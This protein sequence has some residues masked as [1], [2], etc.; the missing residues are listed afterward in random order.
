MSSSQFQVVSEFVKEMIIGN[1]FITNL[2]VPEFGWSRCERRQD[3]A[4]EASA[5]DEPYPLQLLAAQQIFV[6]MFCDRTIWVHLA[7][8][9]QAGKT[10]VINSLY[11]LILS[12]SR[13]IGLAPNRIFTI[14]GMSDD[15]WRE[16]TS[17]RLPKLLREN[18]HHSG[19]LA[20]VS[21]KLESL[22]DE[23]DD[24]QLRNVLIVLDESHHAAS[25]SNRPNTHVYQVVANRCPRHLW[26]ERGIRF[27]TVSATD[28][29]KVL[30]ME[31]SNDVT[32]AVVHLETTEAYQSVESLNNSKRLIPVKHVLN[33]AEGAKILCDQVRSL[34][35]EHGPLIHILRPNA[36]KGKDNNAE[37][38]ALLKKEI[39]G[40]IVIPWDMESKK[41]NSKDSSDTA[42]SISSDI[43]TSYLSEK[44][45]RTT[46]ILL[47]G[48]F[49]AAKTLNDEH[50][51]VL[52]D[53]VGGADST[54]LQS[55]LGRACGYGKSSRS[56]IF[57][58]KS[59][60]DNYIT[61]WKD[62][63]KTKNFPKIT[64]IPVGSLKG[65][66]PG[67]AVENNQTNSNLIL[68]Q[69]ASSPLSLGVGAHVES[70]AAQPPRILPNDDD[71]DAVW[72][73]ELLT[74][75]EA[76]I[77]TGGKKMTP[78]ESTG[79]Y[80]HVGGK[81][82]P[83]TREQFIALRAGKKTAHVGK[84]LDSLKIGESMNKT[85]AFY[86]NPLDSSTVRFVVRTLTR[87]RA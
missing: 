8:E 58:A 75:E 28:P 27:L 65:K 72:S 83:M 66:M 26:S 29:A 80:A 33:T 21:A 4:D 55:L 24:K 34:E 50:V 6:A 30:A 85:I 16:Q 62:L 10:G 25:L 23:E 67:V 68:K 82:T 20:R 45:T 87:I 57:V 48:M 53:R 74:A 63:C 43:N 76:K 2:W 71:F 9:M 3:D 60:V 79:F 52:Y 77:I 54:N 19:S 64:N 39:S 14:T 41:R 84:S 36:K 47:K 15:D 86:E 1:G 35:S 44:P 56:I 78:S 13:I 12:N 49:R 32:A 59:T 69:S 40:C 81:K 38:E 61:L 7:A 17:E 37:V 70:A 46:F 73:A 5:S 22:A 31:G 11:R 42:S 18:V 51:G